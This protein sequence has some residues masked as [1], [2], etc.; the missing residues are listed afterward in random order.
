VKLFR[1][2]CDGNFLG[3]NQLAW[4]GMSLVVSVSCMMDAI[5]MYTEALKR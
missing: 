4:L 2:I 5:R 1:A 3:V